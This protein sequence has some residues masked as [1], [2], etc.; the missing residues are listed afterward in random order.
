ML[1]AIRLYGNQSQAAAYIRRGK[2]ELYRTEEIRKRMGVPTYSRTIEVNE[3]VTITVLLEK[4]QEIIIIRANIPE[5]VEEKEQFLEEEKKRACI[6]S[7]VVYGN[8]YDDWETSPLTKIRSVFPGYKLTYKNSRWGVDNVPLT[9]RYAGTAAWWHLK[10][11]YQNYND[12][13]GLKFCT[14]LTWAGNL[15]SAFNHPTSRDTD[16]N[17]P[18]VYLEGKRFQGV[19]NKDDPD[20]Y[21]IGAC[22]LPDQGKDYFYV[23]MIDFPDVLRLRRIERDSGLTGPTQGSWQTITTITRADLY[24]AV[25]GTSAHLPRISAYV[26]TDGVAYLNMGIGRAT[27]TANGVTYVDDP[28]FVLMDSTPPSEILIY[29]K[30]QIDMKTGVWN[31]ATQFFNSQPR[32][33]VHYNK[34]MENFPAT[35]GQ[36]YG[37]Q[38]IQGQLIGCGKEHDLAVFVGDC[39]DTFLAQSDVERTKTSDQVRRGSFRGEEKDGVTLDRAGGAPF[40]FYGGCDRLYEYHTEILTGGAFGHTIATSSLSSFR[41]FDYN[42]AGAPDSHEVIAALPF[43]GHT[44]THNRSYTPIKVDLV[45]TVEGEE[46]FRFTIFEAFGAPWSSTQQKARSGIEGFGHN[47]PGPADACGP[48]MGH[49]S[50]DFHYISSWFDPQFPDGVYCESDHRTTYGYSV[51]TNIWRRITFH[52]PMISDVFGYMEYTATRAGD[53]VET[54]TQATYYFNGEQKWT[55]VRPIISGPTIYGVGG[56]RVENFSA[57]GSVQGWDYFAHGPSSSAYKSWQVERSSTVHGRH[58]FSASYGQGGGYSGALMDFYPGNATVAQPDFAIYGAGVGLGRVSFQTRE[59]NNLWSNRTK[60]SGTTFTYGRSAVAIHQESFGPKLDEHPY[61]IYIQHPTQV[62]NETVHPPTV[63]HNPSAHGEP[64]AGE[65]ISNCLTVD[66]IKELT[67]EDGIDKD[68][69]VDFGV[70]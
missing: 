37:V 60:S 39:G 13:A 44:M 25:G 56:K 1:P 6:P 58:D 62:T 50:S 26:D 24:A 69:P 46:F 3:F 59:I 9:E 16:S 67:K 19:L 28:N 47:R 41:N 38:V 8:L 55:S 70:I 64:V 21:V 66:E 11:H 12:K 2:V 68:F 22:L 35:G 42:P 65:F 61:I 17:G 43:Y 49:D 5:E 40:G 51:E 20:Q 15:G 63:T 36:R 27:T 18:Y 7:F 45:G 14:M 52:H 54:T 33:R 53:P 30:F 10:D 4:K 32:F 34:F 29:Y 48:F 57:A 23:L 31:L